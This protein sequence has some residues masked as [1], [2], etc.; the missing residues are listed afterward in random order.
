MGDDG[1][2]RERIRFSKIAADGFDGVIRNGQQDQPARAG[3]FVGGTCPNA[4]SDPLSR[5]LGCVCVPPPDGHD[6]EARTRRQ[7]SDGRADL[8]APDDRDVR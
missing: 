5:R 6:I 1:A 2:V 4:G 8:A 3:G 7:D